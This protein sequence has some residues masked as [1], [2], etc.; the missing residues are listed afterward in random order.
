[1][2]E[3]RIYNLT[4]KQLKKHLEKIGWKIRESR[5]GMNCHIR[6][7]KGEATNWRVKHDGLEL[8]YGKNFGENGSG[9]VVFLFKNC[10]IQMLDKNCVSIFSDG[11]ES[12]FMH[13]YNHDNL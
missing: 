8:L 12:V 5:N 2:K 1:M 7:Q 10:K 6:N 9:S 13:F 11:N 3:A 4:R